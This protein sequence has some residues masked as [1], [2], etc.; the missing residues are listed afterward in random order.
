[1]KQA[2][3]ER[4]PVGRPPKFKEPSGPVTV[5]LPERTLAQLERIDQDRAKAIVKAVD[6]VGG[7]EGTAESDVME[8][9]PGTGVLVIPRLRSLQAIPW[10]EMVEIAPG[11]FLLAALPGTPVEK[12]ELGILDALEQ[13]RQSAP[14][15]VAALESLR[16]RFTRLRRGDRVARAEILLVDL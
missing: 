11:R 16:G 14:G 1:M 12:I 15:E 4:A 6:S 13:A 7:D 8:T 9:G 10:L 3:L 2:T 5:T